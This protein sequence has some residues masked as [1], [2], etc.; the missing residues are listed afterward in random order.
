[1]VEGLWT[2]REAAKFLAISERSLWQHTMKTRQ[3]PYFRV[4]GAI[5]YC[6]N[7]LREWLHNQAKVTNWTTVVEP[8]TGA[9]L[10][11]ETEA[12]R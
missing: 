11:Q 4:G 6:P 9:P 1:M 7:Q 5:R 12:R 2:K 8:M 10:L 3:I